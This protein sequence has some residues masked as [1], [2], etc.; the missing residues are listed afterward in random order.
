MRIGNFLTGSIG[1]GGMNLWIRQI[2]IFTIFAAVF[3]TMLPKSDMKKYIRMILGVFMILVVA[4][5][6]LGQK[7]EF[8]AYAKQKVQTAAQPVMDQVKEQYEYYIRQALEQE[9]EGEGIE[10]DEVRCL[11]GT[12]GILQQIKVVCASK[13]SGAWV[14]LR[15][16]KKKEEQKAAELQ[17]RFQRL[18]E[19]NVTVEWRI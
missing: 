4:E 15:V 3:E 9:I 10:I 11:L 12:D 18:L 14:I 13:E 7:V 5:P 6:L 17:E 8:P 19:T 16:D 1:G 2:I